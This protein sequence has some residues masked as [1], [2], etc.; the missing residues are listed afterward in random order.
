MSSPDRRRSFANWWIH[1]FFILFSL[2]FIM[3]LL[4]IL[5]ISVSNEQDVLDYGYKLI[6]RQL[7][8][9]A[10]RMIFETPQQ[11][12]DSYQTTAFAAVTGTILGTLI[13][14]MLGYALSRS[15]FRLRKLLAFLV[16]FTMLFGGGLVPS[17]ILITQYLKLGDTIWVYILPS[18]ATGFH[19][20]IFRTFFMGLPNA[21][22]ESAKIDGAR[23]MSIFFRIVLPLSKPVLA[24]VALMGL[25]SRWNDWY[26]ALIYIRT[27]SLYSLQYN[28]QKILLEVQWLQE[29]YN[30]LPPGVNLDLA[31]MPSETLKMAVMIIVAGPMLFVFPFF[32]KYF[33]R[34]LTVGAIKG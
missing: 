33:A 4:L 8:F 15:Y 22:F 29:N 17:Y 23:E 25:L 31:N 7:D 11:I 3:P 26:T 27:P 32:Q 28:L 16:F 2:G 1:L 5:A 18:L 30:T 19:I 9:T 6:P 13:M 20:I 34:G 14:A 10:Y 21:L 24:T 12:I